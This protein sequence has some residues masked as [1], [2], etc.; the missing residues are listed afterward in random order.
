M[1]TNDL[2]V[3]TVN[4]LYDGGKEHTDEELQRLTGD[5]WCTKK[6]TICFI[7]SCLGICVI[8]IVIG[9]VIPGMLSKA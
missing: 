2:H 5:K 3:T 6:V 9:V 1:T 7:L 8:F 4:A